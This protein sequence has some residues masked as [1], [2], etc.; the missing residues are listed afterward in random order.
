MYRYL[1][2]S[3]T[4]C[5]AKYRITLR[6]FETQEPRLGALTSHYGSMGCVESIHVSDEDLFRPH[7]IDKSIPRVSKK[8][9]VSWIA[10]QLYSARNRMEKS[11][12]Q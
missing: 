8:F 4:P 12:I 9:D 6:L 10:S 2:K 11:N 7:P 3:H 5:A 1:R